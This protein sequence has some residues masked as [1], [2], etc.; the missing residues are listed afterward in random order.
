MTQP[1]L[2]DMINVVN[3]LHPDG[4]ALAHLTDAVV[5]SDHLG[6]VADHLIGHFV[7]QARKSGATWTNIGESMGMSKQAAQQ[8]SVPKYQGVDLGPFGRYTPRARH[9][10]VAAQE[11]ARVAGHDT[12]GTEHIA[13]GLLAEPKGLGASALAEQQIT[14]EALRAAMKVVLGPP[15]DAVPEHIPF[16]AS[17]KKALEMT[18]REALRLGHSYVGTEHLLLGLLAVEEGA[19]ATV[20]VRL[21][22]AKEEV[23]AWVLATVAYLS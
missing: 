16:G 8:R 6:E 12:I 20:L 17:A 10:L 21:G 7:D 4:D 5:V 13:L 1:Q 14:P 23:E 15:S 9:V 3:E 19:A 11:E 18:A 22:L 2:S